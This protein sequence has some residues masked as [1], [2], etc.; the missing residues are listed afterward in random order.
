MKAWYDR[1]ILPRLITLACGQSGINDRRGEIVPL[2]SGKVLEIGCGGGL[3]LAHYS[4]DRIVSFAGVDPHA[5]LLDRARGLAEQRGIAGD[6]REGRGEAIPFAESSFDCVVCTFTL[7]SVADPEAV[8]GEMR[9]VLRPG[10]KVLFL[11]H[12]R[13]PDPDVV[14]WQ[15]RIEP[16]WKPVAGGCHL[17]R[18]VGPS[19]RGAGFSVAPLGQDYLPKAPRPLGWMEWGVA[20]KESA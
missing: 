7:C 4:P 17:T 15:E 1:H 20:R 12:G 8:I 6:F 13:A 11:E 14:L 10:G 3:N 9:R 18:Q 16:W 2:A 5:A 19:L